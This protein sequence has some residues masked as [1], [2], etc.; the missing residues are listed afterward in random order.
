MTIPSDPTVDGYAAII[1][2]ILDY[3]GML[4]RVGGD[5]GMGMNAAASSFISLML[6]NHLAKNKHFNSKKNLYQ[7]IQGAIW[8]G[9]AAVVLNK[10]LGNNIQNPRLLGALGT[11]LGTYSTAYKEY[12]SST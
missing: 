6:V 4:D 2:A 10:V 7:P 8:S 3:T 11:F 5:M 12:H 1:A 9:L